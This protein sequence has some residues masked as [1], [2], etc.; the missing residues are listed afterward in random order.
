MKG[1]VTPETIDWSGGATILAGLARLHSVRRI[2]S[3]HLTE[4]PLND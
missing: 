3:I 4:A 1:G 2:L